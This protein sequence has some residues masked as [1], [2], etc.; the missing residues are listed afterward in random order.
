MV[1]IR[2]ILTTSDSGEKE[3]RR[4]PEQEKDMWPEYRGFGLANYKK[5][6]RDRAYSNSLLEVWQ[7]RSE[8]LRSLSDK[9]FEHMFKTRIDGAGNWLVVISLCMASS[10][11]LVMQ[12]KYNDRLRLQVD[13]VMTYRDQLQM[14]VAALKQQIDDSQQN[15]TQ[16]TQ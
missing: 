11:A 16:I 14:E 15:L 8:K 2:S 5:I 6:A 10:V 13:D 4:Y 9:V 1:S 12:R 3:M 7:T